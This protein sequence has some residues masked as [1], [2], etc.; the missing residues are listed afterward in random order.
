MSPEELQ[1][2]GIS[3]TGAV[4]KAGM[5]LA[6]LDP[7]LFSKVVSGEIPIERASIIGEGVPNPADQK[8]LYDLIK[9]R[10]ASGKSVTNGQIGEMIRFTNEAPTVSETQDS[11]FGSQEMTRSLIP[12]KAEVSAYI[13][14]QL[15]QE[16][17]LF[18]AVANG[19]AAEKLGTAGNVIKAEENAKVAITAAQAQAIYD[20]LSTSAGAINTALDEA[21]Q[22]IAKGSNVTN[23]KT[24]AYQK[25]K[26]ELFKQ[27]Q[28]LA[29]TGQTPP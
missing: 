26:S 4:A 29:G 7:A 22:A 1:K 24:I 5:A 17:K 25:I 9:K 12:E 10:E 8:A 2:E 13:R 15:S 23:A 21:A 16:K 19:N 6:N 3:P 27:A 20:K 14:Q 11:L 18:H 28:S